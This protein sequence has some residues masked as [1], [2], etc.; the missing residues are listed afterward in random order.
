MRLLITKIL[1]RPERTS[2]EELRLSYRDIASIQIQYEL[3][4]EQAAAIRRMANQDL[5]AVF[6]SKNAVQAIRRTLDTIPCK[7]K[8]MCTAPGTEMLIRQWLGEEAIIFSGA[9]GAAIAAFIRETALEQKFVFFCGDKRRQIIPDTLRN[10][11]KDWEEIV[12]YR[13]QSLDPKVSETYDYYLFFSPSAVYSFLKNNTIPR[14]ATAVA[15]GATTAACLQECQAARILTAAEP[16]LS[17]MIQT[18][19]DYEDKK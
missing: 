12:V 7:W 16:S 2:L 15:I 3:S 13:N 19:I 8:I 5:V 18:I 6:T 14:E 9:D 17:S 4:D 1:D 11:R 10:L